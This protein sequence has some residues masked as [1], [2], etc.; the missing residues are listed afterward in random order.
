MLE[1]SSKDW[2]EEY[3]VTV[4]DPDGWDRTNFDESWS[5]L[6]SEEEFVRRCSVSTVICKSKEDWDRLFGERL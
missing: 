1:K 5:E 4:Y 3:Q 2:A 6:I